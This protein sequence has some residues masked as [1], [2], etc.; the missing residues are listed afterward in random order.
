MIRRLSLF[1]LVALVAA[2]ARAETPSGRWEGAIRLPQGELQVTVVLRGGDD[3]WT[4]TIDIPV[5]RIRGFEL[6][7][8]SVAGRSVHFEMGGVPGQPTFAGEFSE[9]GGEIAGTFAQGGQ[10]L[11]FSL[12]RK[13]DRPGEEDQAADLGLPA[14]PVPGKDLLGDWLGVLRPGPVTLRLALHVEENADGTVSAVMDSVDQGAVIPVDTATFEDG[15]RVVL[16]LARVGGR[17]EGAMN[18]DGSAMEG[19]WYQR[20]QELPLTF[21]RLAEPFALKRPQEP[22]GP[23]P[24]RAEDVTFTSTSGDVTLAGT[25]LVPEGDGPFP[26]VAFVSGSG[27]QDRDEALMGHKPFLVMADALA[28]RGIASVRFDDRGTGE[29]TGDH[30]G[31]TVEEFAGDVKGAVSFLASRPEVDRHAIGV[32]GHSEGGL[33]GPMAAAEDDEIDFLVLLAPPAVPLPSLLGRQTRDI[34]ALQGVD[35]GLV[36]RLLATQTAD[37]A[38]IRERTLDADALAEKLRARSRAYEEEF[39]DEER[40]RLGVNEEAIEQGIRISTTPWFRSLVRIDPADYLRE[41]R[42][43]VLALFGGRDVQVAAEENA[44]ALRRALAA[45]GNS[46][47]DVR[48]LPGLNHLFQTAGTGGVEEYGTIEETV[49]PAVLDAIGGWIEARFGPHSVAAP[50]PAERRSPGR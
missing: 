43:P 17:F 22:R 10:R 36:D 29:S 40:E 25:L 14:S 9:D 16:D 12:R 2:T 1:V 5:Q 35:E 3:G 11:P 8:V 46:D 23:F 19:T 18:E 6:S 31:S 30:M 21:H 24:Y 15:G 45:A 49:A 7:A 48:I 20:G 42:V 39:S 32:L 41:I 28:R 44:E 34:L 50:K 4:G 37:L 38:L 27:A 26:A 33:T 47:V 13:E